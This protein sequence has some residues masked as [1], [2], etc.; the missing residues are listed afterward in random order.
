MQTAAPVTAADLLNDRPAAFFTDYDVRILRVLTDRRTAFS[1]VF[2][3]CLIF[4]RMKKLGIAA[5][6]FR[7]T[8][9]GHRRG[10]SLPKY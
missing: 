7:G 6:R 10:H 3:L 2:V 1:F 5:N 8:G 4:D 9:V